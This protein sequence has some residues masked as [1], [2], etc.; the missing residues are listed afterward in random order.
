[1]RFRDY[2]NQVSNREKKRR[3]EL[4]VQHL[5]DDDAR[6]ERPLCGAVAS[7]GERIGVVYYLEC[8]KGGAPVGTVCEACKPLAVPF[9]ENRVRDLEADGLADEAGE[10]RSLVGTLR[11]ETAP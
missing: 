3:C 8:R 9:A 4:K 11:R 2:G 5:F 6:E 1:M 10:F 7:T